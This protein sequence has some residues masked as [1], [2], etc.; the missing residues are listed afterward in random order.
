MISPSPKPSLR[1]WQ[2]VARALARITGW[3]LVDNR[4]PVKKYVLIGAPHTTNWDLY[5]ALVIMLGL[6]IRP[7]WVGKESLFKGWRGPIMRFLGGIPVRRGVS[8]NFVAQTVERINAGD[9]LVITIAPEG[10]RK[11]ADYWKSGFYYI[12]LGANIPIA[13]GF[14]DYPTKTCGIGGYFTPSGDIE[15]DTKILA[16]FYAD[17]HGKYPENQGPVRIHQKK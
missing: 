16:D 11:R 12:A 7:R 5:T 10:T 1:F 3:T 4:P 15:A 9:E 13:M 14:V 17:I 6:G 2:R 8:Q